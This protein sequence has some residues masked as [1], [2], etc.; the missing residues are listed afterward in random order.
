M[1]AVSYSL[2]SLSSNCVINL[3]PNKRKVFQ[4]AF[5]ALKVS[6]LS[7]LIRLALMSV[8]T[9]LTCFRLVVSCISVIFMLI[10]LSH[11]KQEG[12]RYYMVGTFFSKL[13]R[14]TMGCIYHLAKFRQKLKRA[15]SS[16]QYFFLIHIHVLMLCF[17]FE[18]I[19]IKFEFF[20]NFKDYSKIRPKSLY[21][22]TG[23]LAKFCQK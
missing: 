6:L 7:C 15:N 3:C 20:T 18:L 1:T 17:K 2:P 4:G 23:V 10:G 11:R 13:W 5:A 14:K 21:Y 22:S 9:N 19:P 8:L 12:T 16:F